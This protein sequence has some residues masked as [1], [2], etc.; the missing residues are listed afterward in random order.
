VEYKKEYKTRYY[1]LEL[2]ISKSVKQSEGH[3][4][5]DDSWECRIMLSTLG[6]SKRHFSTLG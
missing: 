4:E 2:Q 1:E 5:F 6:S 3:A